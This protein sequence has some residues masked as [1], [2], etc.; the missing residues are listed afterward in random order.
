MITTKLYTSKVSDEW[1]SFI[2]KSKCSHFIFLRDYMDY[3]ADRFTDHS[4]MFYDAKDKLIALMPANITDGVLYSHQ[5]LT[6]GGVL[7]Q[8]SM[9]TSIML[10]VFSQLIAFCQ[11]SGMRKIIYKK[12]PYIYSSVPAD[13]DL[14]ALFRSKATLI[15]RDVSSAIELNNTVKYSKGRKYNISVAKKNNISVRQVGKISDFWALLNDVLAQQHDAQAVHSL[16]EMELLMRR[17]PDNIKVYGA[18]NNAEVLMAGTVVYITDRLVH[19]QYLANSQQGKDCGALD[20]VLDHLIKEIYK[21][22]DFFDFGIS[23]EENG[24]FLN[25]GLIAQKEGF[26]ARAVCHDFYELDIK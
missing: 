6:F 14:Y 2:K 17:F 13:E 16:D 21:D 5:G 4:L 10:D 12:T 15:R 7:S 23:N 3:H 18:Y 11:K 9:K 25:K 26:G 19:T 1:D 22:H 24:Q 20:L 8:N